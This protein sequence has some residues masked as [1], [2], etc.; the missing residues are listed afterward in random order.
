MPLER[1]G[2]L[3]ARIL[4]RRPASARDAHYQLLC[5][6]GTARWRVAINAWSDVKPSEVAQA[7]ITS[8]EHPIVDRVE[9]LDEGWRGLEQGLDYVRGEL[10]RPEQFTPLPL[11]EPGADNDLNELF[12][13]HLRRGARVYAFGEPWGPDNARDPYFGFAP[14]RGIHDVHANQGN[15]RQFRRDDGVW[16]DGG[17]IV[18]A[19]AGWTAILLRFQSQSWRTDDR[20]GHAR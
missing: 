9:A 16:Q 8:F 10:C 3:K 1:Y 14:G 6:V 4:D 15:L 18:E 20:T 5:G 13:R 19:A 2:V 7:A 11:S 17:L 12:D